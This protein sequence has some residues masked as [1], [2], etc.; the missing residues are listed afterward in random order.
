MTLFA[1][2]SVVYSLSNIKFVFGSVVR[3]SVLLIVVFLTLSLL[4]FRV[5]RCHH[6][7][8]CCFDGLSITRISSDDKTGSG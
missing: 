6:C 4:I 3:N 1:S 8:C 5:A 2:I 7:H